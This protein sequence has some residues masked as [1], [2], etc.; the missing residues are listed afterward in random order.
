LDVKHYF[1]NMSF[2]NAHARRDLWVA[3]SARSVSLLGDQ[4]AVVALALRLTNRGEPPWTVAALLIAGLVPLVLFAPLAGRLI[5]TVDSRRLLVTAGVAQVLLCTALVAVSGTAAMLALVAALGVFEAVTGS[6]WQALLP[7][8]VEP[9][10]LPKAMGLSQAGS[11]IAMIAA[12]ALGGVL[13]GRFGAGAV[14]VLDAAT[15]L[16]VTLGALIVHTR[17][18]P[19]RDE[20]DTRGGLAVLRADPMLAALTIMVAVFVVLGAM[21]NVVE[22]FLVRDTLHSSSTWFGVIGGLW[23]VG[24]LAGS[25]LGGRIR[26]S[27]NLGRLL[28]GSSIALA[29]IVS[30]YAAAPTVGWLIPA[31]LLGGVANGFVNLA[32]MALGMGRAPAGARGRIAATFTAVASAAMVGAY[33]LGGLLATRLS[34]R[35][36]Y[37]LAGGLALIA[38]LTLARRVLRSTA[39]EPETEVPEPIDDAAAVPVAELTALS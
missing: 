16:L 1:R 10:D 18:R 6:T 38:P 29:L 24:L 3:V 13:T 8:I 20:D 17:R 32:L 7:S 9:D 33:V 19:E 21:V 22:V 26:S 11:T 23:G 35:E 39:A 28:V 2:T 36:I 12:P 25:M 4:A 15:Y 30:G 5:D 34:P 31:A 37:L 14:L 27:R